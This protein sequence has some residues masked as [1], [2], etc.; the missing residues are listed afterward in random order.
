[1]NTVRVIAMTS[2]E[3]IVAGCLV[4]GMLAVAAA[5]CG[6][7]EEAEVE[8]PEPTVQAAPGAAASP[9]GAAVDQAPRMANAVP[10]STA[11]AAVDLQYE[12]A[13]RPEAGQPFEIELS[14]APRLPADTLD[15]QLSATPGLRITSTETIRF[16]AV[17][18]G[19]RYSS[20]AS[21]IGDAPGLYYVGIVVRMATK[22]QTDARSFSVPVVVG[23][24]P[25][26]T[27][28]P[29][30]AVEAEG[31]PVEPMPA[32]ETGDT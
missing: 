17:Q 5:G 1:M 6:R 13:P 28:Q 24:E 7:K 15:V 20:K 4:V 31:K 32:A 2:I 30:P 22:V 18:T 12:L 14:F 11:G 8:T 3:R 16:D 19:Q 23:T 29:A 25:P 9:A 10:T 26:P 21:V 27:A